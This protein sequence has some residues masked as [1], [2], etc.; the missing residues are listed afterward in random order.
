[1]R[2]K[3]GGWVGQLGGGVCGWGGGEEQPRALL[4]QQGEGWHGGWGGGSFR[5]MPGQWGQLRGQGAERGALV[6]ST[7]AVALRP[8]A[9]SGTKCHASISP[10]RRTPPPPTQTHARASHHP[11]DPPLQHTHTHAHTLPACLTPAA[12]LAP[13]PEPATPLRASWPPAGQHRGRVACPQPVRSGE[14]RARSRAAGR[15]RGGGLGLGAHSACGC[16]GMRGGGRCSKPSSTGVRLA[17]RGG[18][19]CRAST[20]TCHLGTWGRSRAY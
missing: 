20:P 13:L 10:P 4:G 16:G 19:C 12:P 17:R 6:P 3:V 8:P 1:M 18:D 11:T 15:V 7:R 5:V 2:G 14:D 9:L